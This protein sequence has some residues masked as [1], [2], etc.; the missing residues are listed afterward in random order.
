MKYID[1]AIKYLA[2]MFL[3]K[4]TKLVSLYTPHSILGMY[5]GTVLGKF[6]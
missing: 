1:D 4:Q 2:T 6:R 3:S 5:Y